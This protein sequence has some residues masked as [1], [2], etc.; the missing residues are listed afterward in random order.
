MTKQ[1]LLIV[2]GAAILVGLIGVSAQSP[3]PVNG[4]VLNGTIKG[5]NGQPLEG[6]LITARAEGKTI[7]TTVFTDEQGQYYFPP[8]DAGNYEVWAQQVGFATARATV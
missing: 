8:M 5:P 7:K 3:A 1:R 2:V 4:T 6:M